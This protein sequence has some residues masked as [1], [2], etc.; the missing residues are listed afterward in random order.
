VT[1]DDSTGSVEPDTPQ[2][3]VAPTPGSSRQVEA[4]RPGVGGL[5]DPRL[6]P[7]V[8]A[9]IRTAG[10]DPFAPRGWTRRSSSDLGPIAPGAPPTSLIPTTQAGPH[11]PQMRPPA[12]TPTYVPSLMYGPR[13][14]F[15][16]DTTNLPVQAHT[17]SVLTDIPLPPRHMVAHPSPYSSSSPGP[18]D[19]PQLG[20]GNQGGNLGGHV[21]VVWTGGP[22]TP[23]PNSRASMY[24]FLMLQYLVAD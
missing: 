17:Q 9:S 1:M 21:P 4:W 22:Q 10:M 5:M 15:S 11:V 20:H 19:V 18:F 8:Q 14:A 12:F 2:L 24:I 7:S 23:D 16:L 3:G 13:R 6:A